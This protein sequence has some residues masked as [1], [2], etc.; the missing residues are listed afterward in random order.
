MIR[1][2]F[3]QTKA[4]QAAALFL[5]L[6]GGQMPYMKLLKLLYLADR[7]AIR[8]RCSP[9]SGDCFVS[10]EHGPVL[11][12]VYDLIKGQEADS[13]YWDKAIARCPE[14][15][16]QMKMVSDPGV[17]DLS[18]RETAI[19]ESVSG[20]FRQYDQFQLRDWCHDHCR[21][22]QNPAEVKWLTFPK[23]AIPIEFEEIVDALALDLSHGELAQIEQES[24]LGAAIEELAAGH[25]PE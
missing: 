25:L 8:Q 7:E 20:Q 5:R 11:S 6:E 21:E 1:H 3:N 9:V 17:D 13:V 14:D 2:S 16:Y 12:H 18:R 4:T 24:E 10:M 22:W 19:V 23:K 15:P